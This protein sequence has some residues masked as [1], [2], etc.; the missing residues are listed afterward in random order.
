MLLCA[1]CN[2]SEHIEGIVYGVGHSASPMC[3]GKVVN[4]PHGHCG[5]IA[6]TPGA[7][8]DFANGDRVEGTWKNG[9]FYDLHTVKK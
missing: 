6:D 7:Q 4:D 1:G 9:E 2:H 3:V 8:V 5:P